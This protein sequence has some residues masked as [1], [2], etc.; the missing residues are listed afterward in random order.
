MLTQGSVE[1]HYCYQGKP[2]HNSPSK[3]LRDQ[4]LWD[5]VKQKDIR[6]KIVCFFQSLIQKNK[7]KYIIGVRIFKI[8]N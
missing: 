7:R 1:P 5:I 3:P 6:G 8:F 4:H 2:R